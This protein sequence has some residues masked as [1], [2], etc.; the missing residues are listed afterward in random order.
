MDTRRLHAREIRQ[1][2]RVL[3]KDPYSNVDLESTNAE[4]ATVSAIKLLPRRLRVKLLSSHGTLCHTHKGLDHHLIEDIWAWIKFELETAIG[5]FIYPL[6]MSGT[7]S[8]EDEHRIRQLEPAVEMLLPGW[9]LAQSAPPGKK[10]IH[11]GTNWAYQENGCPACILSRIGSDT[12]V[13][14]ALYAGMS[15]HLPLRN[16]STKKSKRLRVI[17]YWMRTHPGGEEA[18]EDAYEFGAKLK[19]LREDA[20]ALLRQYEQSVRYRPNS[21]DGPPVTA[22][23]FLNNHTEVVL[24]VLK[25]DN[26]KDQ[27]TTA[28]LSATT[29]TT[30]S[31]LDISDSY[32]PKDWTTSPVVHDLKLGPTPPDPKMNTSIESCT[33]P[34]YSDK[35]AAFQTESNVTHYPAPELDNLAPLPSPSIISRTASNRTASSK[36][37]ALKRHDSVLSTTSSSSL[38]APRARSSVY[39]IAT[40]IASYNDVS[41]DSTKPSDRSCAFD[42]METREERIEKYRKLLAPAWALEHSADDSYDEGSVAIEDTFNFRGLLLPKPSRTSIYGG[43]GDEAKK[44]DVFELCD[45]TPPPSPDGDGFELGEGCGEEVEEGLMPEALVL[46]KK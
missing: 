36:R 30:S 19:A 24:D 20:K 43:F 11:T 8:T 10:P 42:P 45:L 38:R 40:S 39:S 6:V 17:R 1:L 28:T 41:S 32:N 12:K 37:S 14:F 13:L 7:L 44:G 34:Q 21:T 9:T 29:S 16:S 22:Y 23:H 18:A 26:P 31:T 5:R 4:K 25:L 46:R 3:R 35:R 2:V 15:G 33:N 27:T